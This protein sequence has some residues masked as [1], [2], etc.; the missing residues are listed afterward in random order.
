VVFR[1]ALRNQQFVGFAGKSIHEAALFRLIGH[2]FHKRWLQA[3]RE[4]TRIQFLLLN[5][6]IE[7]WSRYSATSGT[8]LFE[9]PYLHDYILGVFH[10]RPR[11][12]GRAIFGKDGSDWSRGPFLEY[13]TTRLGFSCMIAGEYFAAA[14]ARHA[15]GSEGYRDGLEVGQNLLL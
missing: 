6:Q 9:D 3:H 10:A 8:P 13:L 5:A 11:G 4:A 1:L 15:S 12:I 2:Y 7:N 14:L